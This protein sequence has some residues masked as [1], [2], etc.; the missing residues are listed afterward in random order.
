MTKFTKVQDRQLINAHLNNMHDSL[1]AL[2]ENI[3]SIEGKAT[4]SAAQEDYRKLVCL[5]ESIDNFLS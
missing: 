1:K 2:R 5:F 3:D 4:R